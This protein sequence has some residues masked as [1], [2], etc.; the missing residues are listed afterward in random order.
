MHSMYINLTKLHL[1]FQLGPVQSRPA[2]SSPGQPSPVQSS[3]IHNK[4]H[5][6]LI[7]NQTH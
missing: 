1:N 2:Q 7:T 3:P 5:F 4:V 6:F